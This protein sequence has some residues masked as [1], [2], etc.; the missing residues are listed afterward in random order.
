MDNRFVLRR[1][2]DTD[3]VA[4][5]LFNQQI[6]RETSVNDLGAPYGED[7]LKS[8]F[9]SSV[10]PETFAKKIAD[11]QQ[12]VWI[13]EDK[14]DGHLV[15]FANG[16]PCILSYPD[17]C[18]GKDGEIYRIYVRRDRQGYGLGQWLMNVVLSWLE[19]QFPGRPIWLGVRSDN[20][21]A[22]KLYKHYNFNKVGNHYFK[23]G[24]YKSNDFVMKRENPSS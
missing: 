23:V 9:C 19:E 16:G 7:N 6:F 10:S 12:A 3:N 8:Y 18:V 21:K 14:T 24:Q 4:L 5:S 13:I 20:L 11:P 15:A 2:I 1:A 22:Q 17:V